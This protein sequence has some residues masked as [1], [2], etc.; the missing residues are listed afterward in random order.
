[1][2]CRSCGFEN[3]KNAKTCARC[4]ARLVWSGA[5]RKADFRPSRLRK[6]R[7]YRWRDR[8]DEFVQWCVLRFTARVPWYS[9]LN[10]MPPDNRFWTLVSIIPGAG[11]FFQG[12]VVRGAVLFIIWFVAALVLVLGHRDIV[13]IDEN[14]RRITQL[15]YIALLAPGVMASVHSYAAITAM[16]T[17]DFCRT[18]KEARLLSITVAAIVLFVYF[19]VAF[20]Y[21]TE[22]LVLVTRAVYEEL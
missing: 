20:S 6:G 1:M 19:F 3:M 22:M 7:M 5:K 18:R 13:I 17:Q 15:W 16:R 9:V 2:T 11:Q 12:R 10:R 21:S 4:G 8:F 14:A